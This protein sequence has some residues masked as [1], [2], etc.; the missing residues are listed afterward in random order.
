MTKKKANIFFWTIVILVSLVFIALKVSLKYYM[1]IDI[2]SLLL[3][4]PIVWFLG[5]SLNWFSRNEKI[6]EMGKVLEE[7]AKEKE[8][9]FFQKERV[10]S[11][12]QWS[13]PK[14]S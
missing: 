11:T 8:Q 7:D 2:P 14:I 3:V 13:E 4:I 6:K 10:S 5:F 12:G 1:N 9:K